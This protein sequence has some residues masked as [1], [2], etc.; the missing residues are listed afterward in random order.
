MG[1]GSNLI[2]SR[3]ARSLLKVT[4]VEK[5]DKY[6]KVFLAIKKLFEIPE[7]LQILKSPIMPERLKSDLLSL[8][9]DESGADMQFRN[10][11]KAVLY[12]GRVQEFPRIADSYDSLVLE[13]RN[14]VIANVFM[15]RELSTTL[16]QNLT[17]TLE[18]LFKKK[19]ILKSKVDSSIL[20]GF[21]VKVGNFRLDQ[22]LRTKIDRMIAKF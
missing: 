1:K 7:A 13:S 9:L 21:V 18:S 12:A 17:S 8:A 19:I 5:A 10:L 16:Q 20:G 14:E 22:S 3:Y 15:A 11:V 6:Q 2:A 4:S